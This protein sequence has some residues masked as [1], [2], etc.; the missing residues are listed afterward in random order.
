MSILSAILH[1][2]KVFLLLVGVLVALGMVLALDLPVQLYPQTQRPRVSV[3][4]GHTGYSAVDFAERFGDEMEGRLQAVEG[5]DELRV[6]YENDASRFT[7]TFD[8]QTDSDDAKATTEAAMSEMRSSLPSDIADNYEVR[9]FA[10][11]NAGFLLLGVQSPST[12]PDEIYRILNTSLSGDLGR[13]EDAEEVEVYNIEDLEVDVTLRPADMLAYGLSIGDV[14]AAFGEGSRPEPIGTLDEAE[15][16]FTMRRQPGIGSVEEIRDLVVAKRGDLRVRLQDVA[17]VRIDYTLPRQALVTDGRPA[18]RVNATPKDGGNVRQ[19]SEDVR[20]TLREARKRGVLPADTGFELYVDPAGYINRAIRNVVRAATI[21]AGL[22]MLIV[23][24]TLGE[25]RNTLL[26]GLSLPI[27]L[28]LSFI[29]MYAFGVSVNLISLGGVA[30][31]VGMVIDSSIV[32]MENIH[33]HYEE[34]PEVPDRAHLQQLIL[35]SVSQ[36]RAPVIASTLTTICVFLPVMFTA[37]LANAILGDQAAAVIFALI[38]AL[39]IALTVLPVIARDVYRP[40]LRTAP[41]RPWG[42]SAISSAVMGALVRAYRGSL[43]FIL[44]KRRRS[45]AVVIGAFGL[46]GVMIAQVLPMIPSEIIAPPLSDR[47]VVFFRSSDISD[48]VELVEDVVPELEERVDDAAGEAVD[49]TYAMVSGRFNVL[50][51]NLHSSRDAPGVLDLLEREF[52]SEEGFYF[53][54]SM[55]DPAELPLP[56]TNDLQLAVR[57]PD[58]ARKVLILEELRDLVAESGFYGRV[59]T[60]PDVGLADELSLSVRTEVLSGFP[61]LS[62]DT[63]ISSIRTILRG[64]RAME[65]EEDGETVDVSAKY[66]PEVIEGRERLGNFLLTTGRGPVPLKHFIDLEERQGVAGIAAEDGERIFRVYAR[67]PSGGSQADR[68]RY[69][70]DIRL[71]VM[72][73][74]RLPDGYSIVVDNPQSELDEALRS[75][76]LALGASLVLIY[77]VVAFQFNSLRLPLVVLVSVP[78]GFIGVIASL[79]VFDSTLSLNSM[80]GTILLGGIVVNNSILMID[81]YLKTA[82]HQENRVD[83]LVRAAGLRFT[84]ILITML[85]TILGMLPLAIGFGEGANIVQPLG[86]AVSGGLLV[87]TLFTLYVVPAVLRLMR[88]PAG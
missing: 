39:L 73:E 13:I 32:V 3:R 64:T 18:V 2:R 77:L 6:S 59:F 63:L 10:G 86:I 87:S 76:F 5:V 66:P 82:T 14:D 35:H 71:R 15:R 79:F 30:L 49:R 61:D 69:E 20:T 9:F 70:E 83:A 75:L 21:G 4:V 12:S 23:L 31:A 37:P 26:I 41:R 52:R 47:I 11:E 53:N 81:F 48:R 88:T 58:S 8:W 56:R 46:L 1:R 68:A 17:D 85:T 36:V 44:V 62:E 40:N 55:W 24:L 38:F 50:F 34:E 22:A 60:D 43:R 28:I 84:P 80:L 19:M 51:V 42:L 16:S 67:M 78:L 74:L 72:E 29:L 25:L 33:R 45:A 27:T 57:G 54:V 7:L 65:I